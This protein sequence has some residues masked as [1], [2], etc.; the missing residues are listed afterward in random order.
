MNDIT[1]QDEGTV[2]LFTIQNDSTLQWVQDNLGLEDWQWLGERSFAIDRR[3]AIQLIEQLREL[4]GF[5][6]ME[7]RS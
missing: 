1:Y 4:E 7:V 3:P 2:I 5:T 6:V